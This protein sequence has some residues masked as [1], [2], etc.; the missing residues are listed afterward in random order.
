MGRAGALVAASR[1]WASSRVDRGAGGG[2]RGGLA[3]VAQPT[4]RSRRSHTAREAAKAA[5]APTLRVPPVQVGNIA[6][7]VWAADV[8]SL[9]VA[10][11]VEAASEVGGAVSGR[12]RYEKLLVNASFWHGVVER[13]AAADHGDPPHGGTISCASWITAAQLPPVVCGQMFL[14]RRRLAQRMGYGFRLA[15]GSARLRARAAISHDDEA[16]Q[17]SARR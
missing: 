15:S 5:G 7:M 6:V 8:T 16:A 12:G 17:L 3:E 13:S 11:T 4:I 10:R 9:A 14:E 2:G 1:V